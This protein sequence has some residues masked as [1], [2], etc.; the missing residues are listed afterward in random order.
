MK[1]IKNA[2]DFVK[3][4]NMVLWTTED[5]V[6]FLNAGGMGRFT[7]MIEKTCC[8]GILMLYVIPDRRKMLR[9]SKF[10]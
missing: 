9:M 1:T 4:K 7:E 10:F 8:D 5:I 3:E 2:K 6:V